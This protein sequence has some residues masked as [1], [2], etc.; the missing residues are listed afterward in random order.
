MQQLRQH[1]VLALLASLLLLASACGRGDDDDTAG[2][3]EEGEEAVTPD[4]GI[5][6]DA[7]L[8]GGSYPLSGPASAYAAISVAVQGYFDYVN[9]EL[10]GVEMGDGVTRQI[11][12]TVYDDG[13]EPPRIVENA[14]R[15]VEEDEVFALFNTLGTP[16]NTAIVDYMNEQEVPHL[17]V[18]TGASKWGSDMETWPWTSGWQP[19][20]TT[21]GAIYAEYLKEEYPDGAA[22]AVLYQNDDYGKDYLNGF[23]AA[24]EGSD[25]EVV[26]EESYEVADPTVDSQVVNL[27]RSGA[28]VFFNVTTPKFAT[29]AIAKVGELDWD[30]LHI[31]NNVS[32]SIPT[33]IEPAGFDNADGII[34]AG[35]TKD[36]GDPQWEDDEGIQTYLELVEEYAPD[37]EPLNP[38]GVYGFSVAE[39]IVRTLEQTEE[40]TRAALMEAV[41]NLDLELPLLLP[42]VSV[43]T[44]P[45]DG[46]PIESEQLQRFVAADGAW[47]LFGD[48]IPYE[49]ETPIIE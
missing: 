31:L 41:R 36:P 28:D 32:A 10:G 46:Y 37:V 16:T 47:E 29:Q 17:F 2:E 3:A 4:P 27:S 43:T 38:F 5:T 6:D 18:A 44:G 25:I 23:K 26:Q 13:Y 49:G 9:T 14:R 1:K 39:T 12:F 22:V 42:G 48:L 7:V 21:E 33:V 19:A 8:L 45:D 11:E 35:Y 24:I 40:P 30:P 20:Y 34:T 15:L